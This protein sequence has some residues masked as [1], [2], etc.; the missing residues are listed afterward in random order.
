MDARADK[1]RLIETMRIE[2]ARWD[3]LLVQVDVSRMTV[4][5]VEGR[6]SMR[7][8]IADVVKQE[9]WVASRLRQ[10]ALGE[11]DTEEKVEVRNSSISVRELMDESR[12]AFEQI[13]RIVM[14]LPAEDLFRPQPYEWTGGNPVG[15]A[16]PAYIVEHYHRHYGPIR[17]WMTKR[18]RR[19]R[20]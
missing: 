6:L 16:I 3:M 10:D 8:I 20:R 14:G 15:T 17:R 2:R 7:D 5:G 4:P 9:K 18:R 12:R 13:M 1:N 11:P 19:A